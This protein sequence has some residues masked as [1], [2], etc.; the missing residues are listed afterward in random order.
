MKQV[1]EKTFGGLTKQYYIRQFIFGLIFPVIFSQ[2]IQQITPLLAGI[3]WVVVSA[4]LYPYSR[5]VYESVMDFIMGENVFWVD[6]L[7]WLVVKFFT[8]GICWCFAIF[9]APIGLVYLYFYHSK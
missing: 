2:G 6:G 4:F 5:F 3:G 7:M 8:M 1:I 9:I